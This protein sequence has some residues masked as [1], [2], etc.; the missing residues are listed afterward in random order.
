MA[1]RIRYSRSQKFRLSPRGLECVEAYNKAIADAQTGNGQSAFEAA[2]QAWATTWELKVDDGLYLVEFGAKGLTLSEA[3]TALE[4]CGA[5]AKSVKEHSENLIAKGLIE[6][7][8]A[9]AQS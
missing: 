4:N 1:D 7:A 9:P 3:T 8:P 2:K 6:A 5:N